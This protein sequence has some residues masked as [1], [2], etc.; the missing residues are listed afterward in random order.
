M[1]GRRQLQPQQPTATATATATPTATATATATATTTPTGTANSHANGHRHR[2]AD[3]YASGFDLR[4]HRGLARRHRLA[5]NGCSRFAV[6]EVAKACE[7]QTTVSAVD[8]R[9]TETRLQRHLFDGSTSA[10]LRQARKVEIPI[11]SPNQKRAA[12]DCASDSLLQ[13]KPF[14]ENGILRSCA[15]FGLAVLCVHA[16]AVFQSQR[17]S[18]QQTR[19]GIITTFAPLWKKSRRVL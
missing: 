3:P 16:S 5:H 1:Q 8:A 18:R 7:A 10:P 19:E 15:L 9:L 17:S 4:Q 13:A 2:N 12:S 11:G 14:M 6:A